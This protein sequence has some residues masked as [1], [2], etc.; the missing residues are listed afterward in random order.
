MDALVLLAGRPNSGKSSLFNLVTGGDAHVG[1][2]PGITVDVLEADVSLPGGRTARVADLPGFYSIDAVVDADTD[3]GVARA[4]VERAAN[5]DCPWL[6]VQVIDATQ[7]AMGLRLTRELRSRGVPLLVALTQ[8]DVLAAEGRVIDVAELQREIEAP[9]ILVSARDADSKRVIE[10]AIDSLLGREKPENRPRNEVLWKPDA[11]AK[12]VLVEHASKGSAEERRRNRTARLDA[13]LLH[14][15]VGP[16]SFLGLMALVFAAVFLIAEPVTNTLDA[17]NGFIRAHLFHVLGDGYFASFIC[18]GLFGGAGTVLAFLPQIVILTVAMEL[19]EAS[20]YLARGAFLVDR[21]LRLLGL[22]GRS[23][24]PLLMGHACAV[25]AIASTRVIRDPRERLTTILVLPLMTCSARVPT[26]ALVITAFFAGHSALFKSGIFVFLYFAGIFSGLIA[27]LV[28]RKTTVG[29]RALPLVLEMPA[30]RAPQAKLVARKGWQA[31][32]RFLRDVGTIILMVSALL[33]VLLTVPMPGDHS[34][35]A[36]AIDRSIAA[37]V[38]HAIE[39]VT[40]PAGF[41]WRIDVGLIGS[42]GAREV[43]VGTMGVIFGI[44]NSVDDQAPLATRLREAKNP[45]GSPAYSTASGLALLAFFMLACQ[46][47]ST[48]AAI[49]RETHSWRWP[50]FVLAYTYTLAYV[51]AVVVYQVAHVVST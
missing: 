39:P 50:A 13:W 23:F 29:G 1:N 3:E 30:Y 2:F 19:L 34:T 9:V 17:A 24:L 22:S 16:V 43:M 40:R 5:G 38:G 25:P 20:G 10:K 42:F 45:D 12:Q 49:R 28:I 27:S 11:L 4:V 15:V 47:M 44:E 14:P 37:H 31:S 26:Y 48:I 21:I 46:C 32:T 8:K 18:D 41:D 35:G 6:V 36:R 7:L 33:W 51:V